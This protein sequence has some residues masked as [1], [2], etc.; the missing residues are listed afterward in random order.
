MTDIERFKQIVKENIHRKGIDDLMNWLENTDFYTAPS[1]TR[2]HGAVPGGLCKHSLTV[3]DRLT[4]MNN[5]ESNETLAIV[6][7]FHDLCKVNLYKQSMRNTKDENGKWIQVSYYEIDDSYLPMGHGEKSVFMIMSFMRLTDEEAL[8]IRWHMSGWYSNN[9]G[10]NQALGNALQKY[11]LVLKLQTADA[12]A[13][14]WDR[15]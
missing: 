5:E 12:Q 4:Q 7:L 11:K 14:F 3:Y 2:Y 13:A 9:Q 15:S 6:A 1:S 10:E 8:A